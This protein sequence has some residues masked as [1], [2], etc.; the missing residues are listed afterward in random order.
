[1]ASKTNLGAVSYIEGLKE[2]VRAFDKM[3]KDL[4][5][6]LVDELAEA[7]SP[8]A[9]AARQIILGGGVGYAPMNVRNSREPSYWA[10]MSIGFSRGQS[11]AWV[12][13]AFRSNKGTAQGSVMASAYRRRMEA[14]AKD[15]FDECNKRLGHWL[16]TL[17][18]D[19]GS[20][21]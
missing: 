16:D 12:A 17:A 10:S 14:A 9:P 5:Q 3:D 20:G 15:K 11:Q 21:L 19:W 4:S 18:D 1:M 7:F 8:V 6:D 2:L 13:P